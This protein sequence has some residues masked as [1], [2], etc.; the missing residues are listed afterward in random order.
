[1]TTKLRNLS[2]AAVRFINAWNSQS[3]ND[4]ADLLTDEVRKELS[5][6]DGQP[7]ALYRGMLFADQ[8]TAEA[9]FG[10]DYA[11]IQR[12]TRK[13]MTFGLS[14]WY[15]D[16]FIAMR[17]S[18]PRYMPTG[19]LLTLKDYKQRKLTHGDLLGVE[20][21]VKADI[22]PQDV[23]VAFDR[24]PAKLSKGEDVIVVAPST[25]TITVM[26]VKD[27]VLDTEWDEREEDTQKRLQAQKQTELS[28]EL[29]HITSAVNAFPE[30]MKQAGHP[31]PTEQDVVAVLS[32]QTD[33]LMPIAALLTYSGQMP[34]LIN[35]VTANQS[36]F[37]DTPFKWHDI[38]YVL[39]AIAGK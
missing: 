33:Q 1:M 4:A 25:Q 3:H 32:A 36:R 35:W 21:V 5:D 20:I 28:Q 29:E 26:H 27:H 17:K 9:K 14:G 39:D 22:Q 18:D 30:V 6:A 38:P 7:I 24:L 31:N 16:P 12:G 19:E 15:T 23:I 34:G 13:N 10:L 11:Q 8:A 37:T 2:A